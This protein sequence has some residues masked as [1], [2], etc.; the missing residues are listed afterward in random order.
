MDELCPI[1]I[2]PGLTKDGGQ[3]ANGT[4]GRPRIPHRVRA[5]VAQR[6]YSILNNFL[7]RLRPEAMT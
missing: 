7:K 4:T 2:I 1:M 5:N 6:G 3:T